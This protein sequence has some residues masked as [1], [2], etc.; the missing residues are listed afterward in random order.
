MSLRF[1]I[2]VSIS[3]NNIYQEGRYL[4]KNPRLLIIVWLFFF[5]VLF[6]LGNFRFSFVK[7]ES[8]KGVE[9]VAFIAENFD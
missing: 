7:A 4:K 2:F 1:K 8:M 3:F 5:M 9:I 6:S